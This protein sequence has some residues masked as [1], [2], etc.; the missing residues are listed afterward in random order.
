MS[1]SWDQVLLPPGYAYGFT[2]GPSFDTR[3]RRMDGG[4]ESRVQVLEEPRWF[5]SALRKNFR[6]G[7]DVN[8]LRN[9]FLARRGSLY[10]FL[11]ADPQDL[12][13]HADGFGPPSMGDQII[14]FGDG[15]TTRFR[16]RKQYPDPGGMTARAFVRRV[17][18]LIGTA[19]GPLARL[20]GVDNGTSIAPQFSVSGVAAPDSVVLQLSQEVELVSPPAVGAEVRWGGYFVVPARFSESTDEGFEATLAGF[21]SGE[22]PFEVESLPFD[23]PVPLV[24]GGSP[25]G[26]QDYPSLTTSIELSGRGGFFVE[27]QPTNAVTAYLDDLDSYPTGGPHLLVRNY[28]THTLTIRDRLGGLV[29]TVTA[30]THAWLMVKEDDA[31]NRTPWLL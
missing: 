17:V 25:Y 30:G 13:T 21:D 18:P 14:G 23:D 11:F 10:G 31:G 26:H 7:A 2:G 6:D 8:G 1:N 9:F 22:A 16:L 27:V 12:S 29:G 20:I 15:T 28:G 3:A 5:W 4:G 24:P 19:S